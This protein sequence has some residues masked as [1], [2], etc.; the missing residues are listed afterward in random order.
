M[1]DPLLWGISKLTTP[2]SRTIRAVIHHFQ[3]EQ[4]NWF[5]RRELESSKA[6]AGQLC[7]AQDFERNWPGCLGTALLGVP[8]AN[9]T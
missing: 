5:L 8:I 6:E 2:R 7:A 4:E 3:T 9:A 1:V